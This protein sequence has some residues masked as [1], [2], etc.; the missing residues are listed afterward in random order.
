MS[1]LVVII[2]KVGTKYIF[3]YTPRVSENRNLDSQNLE[4]E[5]GMPFYML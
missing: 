5:C 1:P 4:R 2:G 3:S